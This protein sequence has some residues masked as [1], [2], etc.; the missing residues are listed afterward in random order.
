[1]C[2]LIFSGDETRCLHATAD[3]VDMVVR[4]EISSRDTLHK[5]V[6]WLFPTSFQT[7]KKIWTF[8]Q[9]LWNY[10]LATLAQ[11]LVLQ[12]NDS[13]CLSM[14]S[15]PTQCFWS[16]SPIS[17]A[18]SFVCAW[19]EIPCNDIVNAGGPTRNAPKHRACTPVAKVYRSTRRS[20]DLLP[21]ISCSYLMCS[22]RGS[23]LPHRAYLFFMKSWS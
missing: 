4:C 1:M 13:R 22:V 18:P 11:I 16:D 5:R 23:L 6:D 10:T 15:S 21:E 12:I 8:E 2:V 14:P 9:T 17:S 19:N 7:L 20:S 3:C